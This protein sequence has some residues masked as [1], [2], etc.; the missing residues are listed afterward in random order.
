MT[1]PHVIC[2]ILSS[3]DGRQ[4]PRRWSK[5]PDGTLAGWSGTY[6]RLH[7]ALDGDAW[8]VGRITMAEM[9]KAGP[10]APSAAIEVERRHHFARRDAGSY[11]I[12]LDPSGKLHFDSGEM[13]GDH[14]VVL[15]GRDVPDSH[16][17][18]LTVDGVS[19]I[20]SE[21]A[22]IDLAGM[23]S[24]LGS[25]LGI[26]RLLL[27]GGAGINGSFMGA[28]LVDEISLLVVPRSM[29][30]KERAPPSRTAR[31][32][33]LARS[34]SASLRPR[35]SI[36]A[37]SISAMRWSALTAHNHDK[38]RGLVWRVRPIAFKS[39]IRERTRHP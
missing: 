16:L 29:A 4:S 34:G 31:K 38:A 35:H 14:V 30:A 37:S 5:S 11:A 24:A 17:A 9:M 33:W 12:A 39:P 36:M 32:A 23:L 25:E 20:V 26:R 19:Y 28:G 2:L 21:D 13:D 6:N 1:K 15:L 22:E 10:H 27:E 18:E 3:I 7:N 8:M